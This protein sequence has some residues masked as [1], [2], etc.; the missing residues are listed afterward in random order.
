[1]TTT[2]PLKLLETQMSTQ[3]SEINPKT[4]GEQHQERRMMRGEATT[5]QPE[6]VAYFRHQPRQGPTCK[7]QATAQKLQRETR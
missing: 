2:R 7:T 1:M 4:G 5:R 6:G 3:M